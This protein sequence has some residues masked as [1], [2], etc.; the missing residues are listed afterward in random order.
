ML[1]CQPAGTVVTT[2]RNKFIII[3]DNILFIVS[4]AFVSA[5]RFITL[6]CHKEVSR[7]V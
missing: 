4:G 3:I 7:S 2:K 1:S 5:Y 6:T